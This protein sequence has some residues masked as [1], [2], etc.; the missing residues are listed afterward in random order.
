MGTASCLQYD[1]LSLSLEMAHKTLMTLLYLC[2][3]SGCLALAALESVK[4]TLVLV[5]CGV[6]A[7]S[8]KDI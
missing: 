1:V 6:G 7:V 3:L 8:N 2:L 5:C 4:D